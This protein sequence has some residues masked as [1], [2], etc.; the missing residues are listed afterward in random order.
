[1][2]MGKEKRLDPEMNPDAYSFFRLVYSLEFEL[3]S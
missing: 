1:M 2:N 3:Q